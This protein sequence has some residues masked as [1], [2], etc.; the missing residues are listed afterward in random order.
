MDWSLQSGFVF[1]TVAKSLGVTVTAAVAGPAVS[2]NDRIVRPAADR[3]GV[4]VADRRV[5]EAVGEQAQLVGHRLAHDR[6][7]FVE[8]NHAGAARREGGKRR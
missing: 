2:L 5:L 3:G 8:V 7:V 6:R 1:V 4:D